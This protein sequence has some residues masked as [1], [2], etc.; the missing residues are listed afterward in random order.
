[1]GH[2]D[3]ATR[4]RHCGLQDPDDVGDGETAEERPHGE[5][6][7]AGGRGGELV[8]ERV[9]L[10]VDA[11]QV[12]Q[13]WG[14]EAEDARDLLG[15]EEVGGFVPVY[16]H[17]AQIVAEQ[18]V[19]GVARQKAQTVRDPVRLARGVVVVRFGAL[20]QVANRLGALLVRTRPDAKRDAVQR[21]STS[22]GKHAYASGQYQ[23]PDHDDGRKGQAAH[24]HGAVERAGDV[25]VLLEA[26]TAPQDLGQPELADGALHVGNLA[27]DG[28]RCLDPLRGLAADATDHVGMG[29]GLGGTL[30]GFG[31]VHGRGQWLHDPRVQRGGAVGDDEVVVVVGGSVRDARVRSRGEG[32]SHGGLREGEGRVLATALLYQ[33]PSLLAP[34]HAA[35]TASGCK[36]PG[37]CGS[38]VDGPD[39]D[40]GGRC[41][42]EMGWDDEDDDDDED[43]EQSEQCMGD[44][45]PGCPDGKVR[46]DVDRVPRPV[47]RESNGPATIPTPRFDP[48]IFSPSPPVAAQRSDGDTSVAPRRSRTGGP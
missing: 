47:D 40:A 28:L 32:G 44:G 38:A 16:P 24:S 45:G 39:G 41:G 12:V 34:L 2:E 37:S 46:P 31:G 43:D 4:G 1:M 35:S 9:V 7:E 13:T 36:R 10:H 33:L 42:R 8:A 11:H 30:H 29:E 5:V 26:R 6:L 22:C 25:V 21:I 15:V 19:E 14:G 48:L 27:L 18:V 17:A 3:D 23:G 20:A